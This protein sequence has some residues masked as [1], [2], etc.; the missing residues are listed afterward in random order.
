MEVLVEQP[1][2]ISPWA[3]LRKKWFQRLCES[4]DCSKIV[5]HLKKGDPAAPL[6]TL[7]LQPY[8]TDLLSVFNVAHMQDS[9]CQIAS[10]QPF[11]L[12]LWKILVTSW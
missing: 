6:L 10:G 3:T 4:R 5:A 11:R 12:R 8:L 1:L 7:E 9:V 2:S